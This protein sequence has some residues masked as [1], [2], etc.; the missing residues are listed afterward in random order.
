MDERM[1]P[2]RE[3]QLLALLRNLV[4]DLGRGKAAEELGVDRK[5]LWRGMR[6]GGLTPR[7]AEALER[8]A[9]FGDRPD[10]VRERER[11]DGI[12]RSL[13]ALGEEVRAGIEAV[14][15]EVKAL[16]TAQAGA[17]RAWERRLSEAESREHARD[18]TEAEAAPSVEGIAQ[19]EK[20][21]R[22]VRPRRRH[23]P[24]MVTLEPEEYEEF[25]YGEALPLIVEW[26]RARADH[27][28]ER[29]SRVEQATAWVWMLELEIALIGEHGLTMP[30]MHAPWSA[31]EREREVWRRRWRSLPDARSERRRALFW[32]FVR[33]V[34]TLGIWWR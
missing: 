5:T 23:R 29:K 15:G 1:N 20:G 17:L 19:P 8:R 26:R 14:R 21:R 24:Q 11:I 4:E 30:R 2:E 28:D 9:L 33:R 18:G 25:A 3:E 13:Q 6:D 10:A 32:R 31:M 34:L 12:E 7:L 22:E 16:A 27:L